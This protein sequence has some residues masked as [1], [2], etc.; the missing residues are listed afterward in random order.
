MKYKIS[1]HA[2]FPEED[3]RMWDS[4]IDGR[5][6]PCC[7][8]VNAW[9]QPFSKDGK[10]LRNDPDFKKAIEEDP[11]FNSMSVHNVKNIME[12]EYFAKRTFIEGWES[13]NCPE[14]CVKNCGKL[15]R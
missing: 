11:D 8:I 4:S 10:V 1:C 2:W 5:L 12:H 13:D 6:W 9:D 3:L 7:N 15:L 14:I